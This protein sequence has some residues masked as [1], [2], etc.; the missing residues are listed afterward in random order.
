MYTELFGQCIRKANMF[1]YGEQAKIGLCKKRKYVV[2]GLAPYAYVREF[3]PTCEDPNVLEVMVSHQHERD[4]YLIFSEELES[5]IGLAVAGRP[6]IT[7]EMILWSMCTKAVWQKARTLYREEHPY[8]PFVD[9]LLTPAEIAECL[10]PNHPFP[11][12]PLDFTEPEAVRY[13]YDEE[14]AGYKHVH[15]VVEPN[16]DLARVIWF[17]A[18]I[19]TL[20]RIGVNYDSEALLLQF[21]MSCR[22]KLMAK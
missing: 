2:S 12:T 6:H 15:G 18:E 10:P 22:K 21:L 7:P 17:M 8:T 20:S 16:P 14:V 1:L 11:G 5:E 19:S 9:T 13:I 4:Y 3:A